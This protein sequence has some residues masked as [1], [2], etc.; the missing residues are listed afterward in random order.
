MKLTKVTFTGIDEKTNLER[1]SK[2]QKEYP[3]AEFGILVSYDWKENG[4]RFPDPRILGNLEK[5]G[6][7]LSAHFCGQAAVDVVMKRFK[8]V[9]IL[10]G[11]LRLFNRC[12]LNLK[13][14]EH[15]TCLRKLPPLPF[16]KEVIVQMHT[17]QLCEQFL[18]GERPKFMSYLLDASGG[19]G[20][21]TPIQII[22]SPGIHIGYAGGIGP[23]NVKS[24]LRTLLE[25]NS[26]EYFW[27]DME[28][29]VRTDEW[30]D[31]DKVEHVL[32]TCKAIL[33]EQK[34][35]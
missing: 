9:E 8:A 35:E 3:F 19:A 15:I 21:D 1:L 20:I 11:K 30:L 16:I 4:N 24:K 31:L 22:T 26:D 28:T 5:Y 18:Q 27:I 23:E 14:A 7:N 10:N 25:Y 33:D 13:A 17:L 2:L 6:L 32:K 12:Q 34:F 29:R